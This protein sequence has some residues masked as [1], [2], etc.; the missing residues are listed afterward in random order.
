[1][2]SASG[3]EYREV[4]ANPYKT[5][6]W[7]GVCGAFSSLGQ[8]AEHLRCGVTKE[9]PL[10]I[11][12][13]AS[14]D[15]VFDMISRIPYLRKS[16]RCIDYTYHP[17]RVYFSGN[18]QLVLADSKIWA[19]DW[20]AMVIE[21]DAVAWDIDLV[22][23]AACN[24]TEIRDALHSMLI[25]VPKEDRGRIVRDFAKQLVKDTNKFRI[26]T[27]PEVNPR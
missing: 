21:S 27:F 1:M 9:N 11:W 8:A 23:P 7:C 4:S 15:Q 25:I 5:K 2:Y 13:L 26:C 16:S 20:V 3:V 10:L 14:S 19:P 24:D 18:S 17:C 12:Q 22:I 6:I